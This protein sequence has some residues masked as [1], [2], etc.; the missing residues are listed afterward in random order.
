MDR[1]EGKTST[2]QGQTLKVLFRNDK[3][4]LSPDR[5]LGFESLG[6][7]EVATFFPKPAFWVFRVLG[8]LTPERRIFCEVLS[9]EL[10]EAGFDENQVSLA[11]LL[12][13]V[14]VV[15]FR[16]IDTK[17]LLQTL[18]GGTKAVPT[19]IPVV[20]VVKDAYGRLQ[21]QEEFLSEPLPPKPVSR[22]P[23]QARNRRI[24]EAFT[25]P[26]KDLRFRLGGVSFHRKPKGHAETLEMTI[27]NHDIREEFEAV[28]DYFSNVLGTK[29]I[30]VKSD[31]EIIG[32]KVVMMNVAS[33][34][35]ERID[36][37]L[38]DNVKFEFVRSTMRKRIEADIDK[39]LFTMDEYLD[40]FGEKGLRPNA[41]HSNERDL[42]EDIMAVS[43]TRHYRH[44]RFLS[45]NHAH[46]IMKLRFVLK[47][48]SFIFLLRGDRHFH[49]VWE[50]L[51]TEEATYVW[52]VTGGIEELKR[53]L[54]KV[55]DIINVIKVQGK[56]A[57]IHAGDD[58]FRRIIHDYSALVDG[59]VKW[60]GEL[61]SV[62]T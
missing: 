31:L 50:T 61:E 25:V 47:P 59:F 18:A 1:P 28:K 60:K 56:K 39:N 32:G 45:D 44:L 24:S 46:D 21:M 42:F 57:Y 27:P 19:S 20:P 38:I 3:A 48:F 16:S 23:A 51:D 17:G 49:I 22:N 15:T 58:G 40:R 7:P 6:L 43:D 26:F 4:F 9:Y 54:R 35:I 2:L 33:P 30:R 36:G 11:P 13:E 55:E 29:R 12:R 62:L 52:H 5:P 34:E 14:D 37:E 41:F 8:H 53:A 10:G